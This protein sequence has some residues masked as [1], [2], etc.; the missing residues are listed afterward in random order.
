MSIEKRLPRAFAALSVEAWL[1]KESAG[2]M[3]VIYRDL[4]DEPSGFGLYTEWSAGKAVFGHYGNTSGV[5]S[6]HVVQDGQWHHVVGTM[7]PTGDGNY[8][9]R[10]YVDGELDGEQTG[11]WSVPEAPPEGGILMIGYPNKTGAEQPYKGDVGRVTIFDVELTA[12]KVKARFEAQRPGA[13][14]H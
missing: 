9:Y 5:Q 6:E 3:S 12:A 7:G 1:R 8:R 11:S 14:G 13:V 4:W 2:W 10:I